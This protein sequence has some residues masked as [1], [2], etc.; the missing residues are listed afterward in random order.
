MNF[1]ELPKQYVEVLEA[2]M[3]AEQ[4]GFFPLGGSGSIVL[5]Y[6]E[7]CQLVKIVPSVWISVSA[8]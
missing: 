4:A 8:P 6:N 5:H 2:L 3:K 7:K 1:Q